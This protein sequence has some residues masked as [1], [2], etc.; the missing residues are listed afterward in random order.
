MMWHTYSHVVYEFQIMKNLPSEFL[1]DKPGPGS[2]RLESLGKVAY[3]TSD[4]G[5]GLQGSSARL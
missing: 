3:E 5:G 2:G 1:A 4:T